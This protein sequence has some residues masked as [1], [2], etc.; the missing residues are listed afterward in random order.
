MDI[1]GAG[2]FGTVFK[3]RWHEKACAAKVLSPLGQEVLT[4]IPITQQAII[5]EEMLQKFK[6][7]CEFMRDCQHPNIVA[8]YDT[9]LYP[10]CNLPVLVM[11][12]MQASLSQYIVDKGANM[13][14]MVQISLS[15]DVA[16]ALE[17]L[18][19]KNLIH[20]DLCS[21]NV[22]VNDCQHTPI[23]KIS[24]FGISRMIVKPEQLSHTLTSFGHREG[25]LP[26]EAFSY[27]A[28]YDASLD[29]FMLGVIMTLIARKVP[30][31]KTKRER[32]ELVAQLGKHP[33][34]SCIDQCLNANKEE[35]CDAGE[36]YADLTSLLSSVS[37]SSS[38][39]EKSNVATNNGIFKSIIR[40]LTLSVHK[41]SILFALANTLWL[42]AL[43]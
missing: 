3:G 23:A 13:S 15:R 22:L 17:F 26:R 35:R 31:V 8:Y 1:L 14:L 12:L 16:S 38:T 6:R 41:Y 18:H 21:D 25:Y 30:T 24:D 19:D 32:Y 40:G 29:I 9:L 37:L 2:S 10:R 36:L 20:R 27:P 7:E 4:G 42:C 43:Y 39:T 34:K 28:D 33:L 11:E 5:P